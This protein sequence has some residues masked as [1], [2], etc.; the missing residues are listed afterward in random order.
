MLPRDD[1]LNAFKRIN[2]WSRG[3]ERAPH[4]PL[5]ALYALAQLARGE[6]NSIAFRDVA[7]KRTELFKECAPAKRALARKPLLAVAE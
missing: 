1:I 4:T 6:P 2:V 7:P 3:S 5:L